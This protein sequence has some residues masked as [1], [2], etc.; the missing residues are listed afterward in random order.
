MKMSGSAENRRDRKSMQGGKRGRGMSAERSSGSSPDAASVNP[1]R[2]SQLLIADET[3]H[4][5][6]KA[7]RTSGSPLIVALQLAQTQNS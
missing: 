7:I 5:I 1:R 2:A 4:G 6:E 3:V